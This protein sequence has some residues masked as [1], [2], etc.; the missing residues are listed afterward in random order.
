MPEVV[1]EVVLDAEEVEDVSVAPVA[2]EEA[3]WYRPLTN[4]PRY[5][6]L[7][8]NE[9]GTVSRSTYGGAGLSGGG[10]RS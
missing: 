3:W 6:R 2:A 10:G 9:R 4:N 7:L 5:T 1:S 8:V